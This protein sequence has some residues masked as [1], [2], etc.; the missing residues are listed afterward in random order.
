MRIIEW[1]QHEFIYSTSGGVLQYNQ[2]WNQRCLSCAGHNNT[3]K[4]YISDESLWMLAL[5]LRLRAGTA[6]WLTEGEVDHL[7]ASILV[8]QGPQVVLEVPPTT[9][10]LLPRDVACTG[11][12]H[13]TQLSSHPGLRPLSRGDSCG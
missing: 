13:F 1:K 5:A 10:S 2:Q 12:W 6:D 7:L 8:S 4:Y 3:T 11:P 9:F